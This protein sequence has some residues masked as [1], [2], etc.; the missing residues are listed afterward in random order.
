MARTSCIDLSKDRA[1]ILTTIFETRARN[2]DGRTV[3]GA[4][5]SGRSFYDD[6]SDES[7]DSYSYVARRAL[8]GGC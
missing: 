2:G 1:Q 8:G 6:Q 7:D 5:G 3:G 4:S